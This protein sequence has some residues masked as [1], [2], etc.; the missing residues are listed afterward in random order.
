LCFELD[1]HWI[2]AGGADP[3][4]WIHRVGDRQPLLHLKDFRITAEYKRQFAAVGDGNLNWK[5]ILNAAGEHS[6]DYYLIEQD[7]CYGEDEFACLERS[8][9]YL[10]ER[11][12]G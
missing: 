8:Y 6:I 5:A 7:S 9:R 1:T 2:V 11:G 4:Q 10:S 3:V 12:L